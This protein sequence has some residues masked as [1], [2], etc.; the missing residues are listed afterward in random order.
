MTS[1]TELALARRLSAGRRAGLRWCV[2]GVACVHAIVLLAPLR[3]A[4]AQSAS[5]AVGQPLHV[6]LVPASAQR[7]LATEAAPPVATRAAEALQPGARDPR[8]ALR[9]EVLTDKTT[10]QPIERAAD[11][12]PA[13]FHAADVDADYLPRSAL[14]AGPRP[15]TPVV[16]DYPYFDGEA[17][18]YAGKFDLFIDD[19]GGVVRVASATPDLPGILANAVREAFLTARFSPGEVEGRPVRSRMRI[20]VTFDSRR[21]PSS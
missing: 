10:E 17:D 9:D 14:T 12:P 4:V 11:T 1:R 7:P 19:T 18:Q 21:L 15:L 13:V 6:R 8:S 16:I 20:E 5:V 3:P 2:V